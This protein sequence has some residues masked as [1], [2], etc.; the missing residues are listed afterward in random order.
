M[1]AVDGSM[2]WDTTVEE[3]FL[4]KMVL[5]WKMIAKADFP[6]VISGIESTQYLKIYII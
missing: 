4:L 5:H 1:M 2:T 6:R 3:S